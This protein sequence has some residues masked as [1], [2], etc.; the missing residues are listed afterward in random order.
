MAPI[1]THTAPPVP[2]ALLQAALGSARLEDADPDPHAVALAEAFCAGEVTI[3]KYR[4]A[5]AAHL[6]ALADG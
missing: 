2:D 6:A 4:T 5:A 3:T 1:R